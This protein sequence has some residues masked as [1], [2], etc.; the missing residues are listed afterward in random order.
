[1]AYVEDQNIV[2][3]LN[4]ILNEIDSKLNINTT[5]SELPDIFGCR[6]EW[7][8]ALKERLKIAP[9]KKIAIQKLIEELS[10][11]LKFEKK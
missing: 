11:S 8:E 1:L 10:D 3:F 5:L 6:N 4:I 7:E 2:T 9:S